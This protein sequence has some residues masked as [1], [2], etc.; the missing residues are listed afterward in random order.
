MSLATSRLS[1]AP[2]TAAE[3]PRLARQLGAAGLIPFALGAALTWLVYPEAQPLV[4]LA[5]AGYAACTVAFLGGIHWGLAMRAGAGEPAHFAWSVVP[6]IVAALGVLMPAYAGLVLLG[7][8]LLVCY[9]V[10]RRLYAVQGQSAWLTL[11]FRLSAVAS[12]CCFIGAAG[13]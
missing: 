2:S 11:R 8:M 3:P 9:A 1:G 4:T 5:L 7:A 10:D 13:T 12:L 6:P